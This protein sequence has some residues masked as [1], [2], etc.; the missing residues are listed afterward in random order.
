ML[1][2]DPVGACRH[3]MSVLHSGSQLLCSD[4][5]VRG[6]GAPVPCTQARGSYGGCG[7]EALRLHWP[8]IDVYPDEAAPVPRAA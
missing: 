6:A 5:H 1:Q 7:P 4:S 8:A 3:C 2:V